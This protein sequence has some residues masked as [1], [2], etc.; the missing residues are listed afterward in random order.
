MDWRELA[1]LG[2]CIVFFVCLG[3]I[4]G[5]VIKQAKKN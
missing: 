1:V 4:V 2:V 3:I 5:T